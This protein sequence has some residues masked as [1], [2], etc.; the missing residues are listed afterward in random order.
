MQMAVMRESVSRMESEKRSL[1]GRL[2][3]IKNAMQQ[4]EREALIR[5]GVQLDMAAATSP[6]PSQVQIVLVN[7]FP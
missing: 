1:T 3:A 6:H 7:T 2:G 5:S 4:L